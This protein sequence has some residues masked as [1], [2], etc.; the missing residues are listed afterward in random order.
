MLSVHS[1]TYLS[2]SDTGTFSPYSDGEKVAGRALSAFLATLA[3]GEISNESIFLPVTIRGEM[4]GRTM[5]GGVGLSE[6]GDGNRCS[7]RYLSL[8]LKIR[9]N[10][11]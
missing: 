7:F 11:R 8:S 9:S 5:R 4:S 1:V 6:L 2:G 10:I 3:I